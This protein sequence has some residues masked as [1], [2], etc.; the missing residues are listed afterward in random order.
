MKMKQTIYMIDE[1][2][3]WNAN[4][5]AHWI[6]WTEITNRKEE[7]LKTQRMFVFEKKRMKKK[8]RLWKKNQESAKRKH[9][10]FYC[11]NR[12]KFEREKMKID[13][14]Q[15]EECTDFAAIACKLWMWSN[16]ILIGV[17]H[18]HSIPETVL[19]QWVR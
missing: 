11:S 3:K 17:I 19:H 7:F 2:W 16:V 12:F 1:K 15:N 10:H 18:L 8:T 13:R 6:K 5:S 14:W 9:H 4:V